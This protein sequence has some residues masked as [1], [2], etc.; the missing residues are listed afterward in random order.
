VITRQQKWIALVAM[1][2]TSVFFIN[3]CDLMFQCGC[4]FLWAGADAHCNIHHGP[5]RCPFCAIGWFGQLL[6]WLSMVM[7]QMYVALR[8]A[9]WSWSKR[10]A[11]A[12]LT[13]PVVGVV[14]VLGVGLW[15]GYWN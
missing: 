11:I 10:L 5:K 9:Q 1:T 8:K 13:F 6:V 12:L 4:T 14:P 3:Y 7:P 2:F 15:K